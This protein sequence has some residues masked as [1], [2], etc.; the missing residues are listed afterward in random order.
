MEKIRIGSFREWE[1]IGV[2][3]II[4]R[5][6]L[7]TADWCALHMSRIDDIVDFMDYSVRGNNITFCNPSIL[8]LR[9]AVTIQSQIDIVDSFH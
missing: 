2:I 9:P 4:I 1:K 7:S 3:I 8:D 5:I 6:R